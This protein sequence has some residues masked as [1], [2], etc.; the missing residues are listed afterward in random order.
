MD[1]VDRLLL[2]KL[3]GN[4]RVSQRRLAREV[5]ISPP[6]IAERLARL[7]RCGVIRGYTV[8]VDWAAIGYPLVAYIPI[9]VSA[10]ADAGI[11]LS[12]LCV[13]PELDELI[14][15]TGRYD[16]LARF[17]L[18]GHTHLRDLLLDQLWHIPG[19]QRAETLISLGEIREGGALAT[20][21]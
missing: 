13:I 19:L 3:A 18:R 17:R 14:V 6:T 12:R 15:V 7:E 21:L 10:G 9:T 20:F 2:R 4:S 1:E 11:I 16:L 5:G 8:T